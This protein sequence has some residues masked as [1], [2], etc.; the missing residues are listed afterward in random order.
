MT[1]LSKFLVLLAIFLS[2]GY[3]NAY[4][5]LNQVAGNQVQVNYLIRFEESNKQ[6]CKLSQEPTNDQTKN[7]V[8]PSTSYTSYTFEAVNGVNTSYTF[9]AVDGVNHNHGKIR[10]NNQVMFS[11]ERYDEIQSESPFECNSQPKRSLAYTCLV[12]FL[13]FCAIGVELKCKVHSHQVLVKNSSKQA[14]G[15]APIQSN[16]KCNTFQMV[17]N[18]HT[19]FSQTTGDF[20]HGVVSHLNNCCLL[21]LIV[22]SIYEGAQLLCPC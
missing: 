22:D 19:H 17:A 15:N 6:N 11:D 10:L 20:Q 9:E 8:Q 4:L 14:G 3:A 12:L 16:M 1:A 21:K 2:A 13:S 5:S 18:E 7:E